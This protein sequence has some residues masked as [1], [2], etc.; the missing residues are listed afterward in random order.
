M[1][2]I[3]NIITSNT[4]WFIEEIKYLLNNRRI[5]KPSLDFPIFSNENDSNLIEQIFFSQKIFEKERDILI[6]SMIRDFFDYYKIDCECHSAQIQ[7]TRIIG[8]VKSEFDRNNDFVFKTKDAIYRFTHSYP[9]EYDFCMSPNEKIKAK[10]KVKNIYR[11]RFDEKNNQYL[12]G[13]ISL[14][15]FFD[16]YFDETLF[17]KYMNAVKSSLKAVNEMV[18]YI[19]IKSLS[20]WKVLE[21]LKENLSSAIKEFDY[22]FGYV[23]GDRQTAIFSDNDMTKMKK[24]FF[25]NN[26]HKLLLSELDFSK[27]FITSEYLYST[28]KKQNH[29]D[30]SSIVFGYFKAFELLISYVLRGSNKDEK[31]KILR[32]AKSYE[33]ND[34]EIKPKLKTFYNGKQYYSKVIKSD[35]I[36][37]NQKIDAVFLDRTLHAISI[38][39]ISTIYEAL[40]DYRKT[41]RNGYTHMDSIYSLEEVERI[42]HNTWVCFFYLLSGFVL[43]SNDKTAV[44]DYKYSRLYKFLKESGWVI[45]NFIFDNGGRK[46]KIIWDYQNR[47]KYTEY[48]A[49][50]ATVS[51]PLTFFVV[52][53]FDIDPNDLSKEEQ[54]A[55]RKITF[56]AN[57]MP[58]SLSVVYSTFLDNKEA[59]I[60][61]YDKDDLYF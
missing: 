5:L 47:I 21:E 53:D 20:S 1:G 58:E 12:N 2:T 43:T 33:L 56:D 30:Y 52:D 15:E 35:K 8:S 6:I 11:I 13:D 26:N 29:F 4:S 24:A 54:K 44:F 50:T 36:T 31:I 61:I 34:E 27:C 60:K 23:F 57:N 49:K 48:D 19:T 18:G 14:R 40:S 28:I 41:C 42:R 17:S 51:T 39:G 55:F 10:Y 22:G 45:K 25:Q 32:F 7:T 59:I 46:Q 9:K 16:K 3:D 37:L 38:N